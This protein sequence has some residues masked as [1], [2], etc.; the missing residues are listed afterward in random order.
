MGVSRR[1][2]FA[3]RRNE[4]YTK[5]ISGLAWFL[6]HSFI[7]LLLSNLSAYRILLF[8]LSNGRYQGRFE[9]VFAEHLFEFLEVHHVFAL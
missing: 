7:I 5:Q 1:L 8:Q 9:N 4:W 6:F 3:S 2:F